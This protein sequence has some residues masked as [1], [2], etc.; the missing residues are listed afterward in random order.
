MARD[1]NRAKSGELRITL[2]QQ[3]IDLLDELAKRGIYGRNK[4]EVAARFIDVALE[5]F[6]DAPR[7]KLEPDDGDS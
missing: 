2:S 7:L 1:E 6:I 5:R 4:A 3:S